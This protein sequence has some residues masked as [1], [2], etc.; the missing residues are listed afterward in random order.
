[1]FR[2]C[3]QGKQFPSPEMFP[4]FLSQ[5]I[6]T[7]MFFMSLFCVLS[8]FFAMLHANV[9]YDDVMLWCDFDFDVCNMWLFVIIVSWFVIVLHMML[10]CVF[11]IWFTSI[12]GCN[13]WIVFVSLDVWILLMST[14]QD[15]IQGVQKINYSIVKK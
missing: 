8:P 12:F 6:G 13:L 2:L 5:E 7:C 1:M 9:S 14:P 4:S 3:F 11:H 15:K 10:W